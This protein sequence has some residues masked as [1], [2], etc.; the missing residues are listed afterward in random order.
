M[1]VVEEEVAQSLADA[2]LDYKAE[3]V[4]S[5]CFSLDFY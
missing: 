5:P 4:A 3:D 2:V 1:L